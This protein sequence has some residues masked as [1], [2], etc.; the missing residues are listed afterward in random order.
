MNPI[1]KNDQDYLAEKFILNDNHIHQTSRIAL[2]KIQSWRF[3]S[4]DPQVNR[5][6]YK[7]I[8]I[9]IKDS[10]FSFVP[11]NFILSE[12]GFYFSGLDN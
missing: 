4:N 12:E 5:R 8:E 3:A 11:N 2:L 6:Y 10:F 1:L 9:R 7:E